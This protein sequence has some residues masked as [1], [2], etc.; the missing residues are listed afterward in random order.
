MLLLISQVLERAGRTDEAVEILRTEMASGRR[1]PVN[2]PEYYAKLV[3][4]RGLVEELGALAVNEHYSA[5]DVYAK[6]LEDTGRAPE[7]EALLRQEIEAHDHP[8]DRVALMHLLV[9]QGRIDE[10]VETG[11]PTYDYY[12]C[13][14][15][16]HWALELLVDDGRPGQ[17]LELLEGLTGAYAE[18]HPDQILHLRLWLLGEAGRCTEGISEATALNER[19]PGEWD[20]ALAQ[21]LER[22]GQLEEAFALLRSSTHCSADLDLADM[23]VRQGRPAEALASIPTIAEERA[24][25]EQR[26]R[27]ASERRKQGDPWAEVGEFT[28]EPRSKTDRQ[29]DHLRRRVVGRPSHR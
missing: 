27:E 24:A 25:A 3:A 28:H 29:M 26:E 17:A 6:A 22:D 5:F 7:A 2:F 9:R 20:T 13:W 1:H 18:G 4:R 15:L 23:L 12:D 16:L 19:E 10:A 11:R 14:N 21:L 8:K